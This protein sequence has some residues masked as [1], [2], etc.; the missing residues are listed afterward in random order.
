MKDFFQRIALKTARWMQGRYGLDGLS[1]GLMALGII[2]ML[3]SVLPYLEAFSWV[4]LISMA[5]ALFRTCSKN[6]AQR[7]KENAV[8]ERVMAKPKRAYALA[9]KKWVNRKTTLY[10]TCKNCGQALSVPRGKGTL[11]VVCP[12]CKTEITKKS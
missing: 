6:F 10:F 4:A 12:K 8:Y 5:L 7:R 1:N 9:K 2:S 11:R 3:L